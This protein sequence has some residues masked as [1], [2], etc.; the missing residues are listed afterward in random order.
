MA[1]D[2]NIPSGLNLKGK[3]AIVTG[4]NT[5]LGFETAKAL[6]K[7]GATIILACRN[8]QKGGKA[9]E[10]ILAE[11]VDAST[12]VREIDL[13][14]FDSVRAFAKGVKE[15]YDQLHFLINNAGVM[16]PPFSQTEQGHELQ[17]GVNHLG[18]FLLVSELWETIKKADQARVIHLSSMAHK[19]GNP[20]SFQKP[21]GKSDYDKQKAYGNSKLACLVFALE[22]QR[23]IESKG[24]TVQSLAA[25]PGIADTE[26]SRYL[27]G[28]MKA[29]TPLFMLFA[30]HSAEKGAQP[31]LRAAL[32]QG[33]VGGNYVGPGGFNEY[34]GKPVLV[35]P[36]PKALSE[37]SGEDLWKA[38]ERQIGISFAV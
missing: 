27:P 9:E 12:E 10:K 15:D 8:L 32:D 4:A 35:K 18:H 31:T 14:D 17:W 22:L 33:L 19:W 25:H 29:L 23:K 26:L 2:W 38:S 36:A 6:S 34:K 3:V 37:K 28:W 11:H 13:A 16:M 5:G 1:K 20:S 7:T 30:A 21:I 24:L